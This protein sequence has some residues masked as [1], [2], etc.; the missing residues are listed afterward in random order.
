MEK[1]VAPLGVVKT[2]LEDSEAGSSMILE[3]Y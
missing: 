2:L 3:A 1:W